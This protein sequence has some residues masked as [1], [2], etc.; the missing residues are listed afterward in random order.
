MNKSFKRIFGQ[1]NFSKTIYSQRVKP[2]NIFIG[3]QTSGKSNHFKK[4]G[5]YGNFTVELYKCIYTPINDE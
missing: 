4:A 5:V 3:M 1:R 2:Q